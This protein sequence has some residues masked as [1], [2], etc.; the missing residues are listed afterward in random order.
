MQ[1][2]MHIICCLLTISSTI[3]STNGAKSS[4]TSTCLGYKYA[5]LASRLAKVESSNSTPQISWYSFLVTT[6]GSTVA[7]SCDSDNDR[8]LLVLLLKDWELKAAADPT[9]AARTADKVPFEVNMMTMI[10][11]CLSNL[12]M[13]AYYLCE[14][15]VNRHATLLLIMLGLW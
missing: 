4:M 6:V 15:F 8:E 3:L 12:E 2:M 14:R 11:I 7:P 1:I 5:V 13:D 10:R 9:D